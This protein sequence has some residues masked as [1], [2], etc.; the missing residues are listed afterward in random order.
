MLL[1][2][3]FPSSKHCFFTAGWRL[4]GLVSTDGKLR[5]ILTTLALLTWDWEFLPM[6]MFN[7]ILMLPNLAKLLPVAFFL[8][9]T[10][11]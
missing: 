2:N 10:F 1:K 9:V 8:A 5:R 11:H 4:G 7:L 3:Y 6:P